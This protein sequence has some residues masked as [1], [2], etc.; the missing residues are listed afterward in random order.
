MKKLKINIGKSID[1]RY[2]AI[3]V[4]P[5]NDPM[6]EPRKHPEEMILTSGE[7]RDISQNSKEFTERCLTIANKTDFDELIVEGGYSNLIVLH[8][9]GPVYRLHKYY[10]KNT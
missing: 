10:E 2:K 1:I 8:N 6:V 4:D 7:I 9:H 3:R 5:V